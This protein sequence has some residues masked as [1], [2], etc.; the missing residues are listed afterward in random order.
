[1]LGVFEEDELEKP[2]VK[3]GPT[4]IKFQRGDVY[5]GR[6]ENG[7]FEGEGC[8]IDL[9]TYNTYQGRWKKGKK[10]GQ[11]LLQFGTVDEEGTRC[12]FKQGLQSQGHCKGE[13]RAN[14]F[15]FGEWGDPEGNL[16][17]SLKAQRMTPE[18]G[19]ESVGS[20]TLPEVDGFFK[21]GRLYGKG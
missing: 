1:V 3:D 4:Q 15:V 2:K 17:E 14:E 8:L 9:A 16:Y 7:E 13:F 21:E 20:S 19:S 11:G 12:A 5:F 18:Q 6:M 10:H